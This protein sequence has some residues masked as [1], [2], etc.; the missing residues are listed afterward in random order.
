M[1]YE[2]VAPLIPHN[3]GLPDD[4]VY[5]LQMNHI[6]RRVVAGILMWS[7]ER[8]RWSGTP[9]E[10]QQATNWYADLVGDFYSGSGDIGMAYL[11][12]LVARTTNYTITTAAS[13]IGF[14]DI[15]TPPLHDVGGFWDADT[16]KV[17]TIPEGFAGWY[18]CY[19][20]AQF[21]PGGQFPYIWLS[22][23]PSLEVDRAFTS[24]TTYDQLRVFGTHYFEDSDQI[25]LVT[26]IGSGTRVLHP[27]SGAYNYAARLGLYRIGD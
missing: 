25:G 24:E 2:A 27:I 19:G 7:M 4:P 21:D 14:D 8:I 18:Y 11:G 3:A 15:D 20:A 5:A 17:L 16:P 13:A 23:T 26:Q 9:A 12:A 22:V 6:W 10:I 1:P